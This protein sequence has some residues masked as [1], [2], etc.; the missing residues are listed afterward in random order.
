MRASCEFPPDVLRGLKWTVMEEPGL[1][2]VEGQ[3]VKQA[4][5]PISRG[6]GF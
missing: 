5:D 1:L 3:L 4:A 6:Q 2:R